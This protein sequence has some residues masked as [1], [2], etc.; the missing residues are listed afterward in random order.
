M[1]KWSVMLGAAWCVMLLAAVPAR[2]T[3]FGVTTLECPVC[4]ERLSATEVRSY[5]TASQDTDLLSHTMGAPVIPLFPN[6]CSHCLYSGYTSDFSQVEE[7]ED[8]EEEGK[9]EAVKKV[10]LTDEQKAKL[11]AA[12]EPPVKIERGMRSDAIA[13][14]ARYDLLAQTYAA[15]GKPTSEVAFQYLRGSWAERLKSTPSGALD[16]AAAKAMRPPGWARQ[17]RPMAFADYDAKHAER[18]GAENA[19]ALLAAIAQRPA[20]RQAAELLTEIDRRRR[21]GDNEEILALLP[22]LK[23]RLPAETYGPY[24]KALEAS[25]AR[26]RR[27]QARAAEL[28]AKAAGEPPPPPD[29]PDEVDDEEEKDRVAG[30]PNL[31]RYLAGELHRRLGHPAEAREFLGQV[32]DAEKPDWVGGLAS[33]QLKLLPAE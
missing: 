14:W 33:G 2:A 1:T 32:K 23:E 5:T 13:A 26:E 31:M 25:I 16:E 20:E 9:R 6:T 12:L 30:W 19:E 7:G 17:P 4:G 21:H 18:R 22:A 8:G 27:H 10:E 3:T 24:A 11:R 29:D 28:F 15:L